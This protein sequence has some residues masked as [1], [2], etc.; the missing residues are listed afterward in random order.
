MNEVDISAYLVQVSYF[1]YHY[2]F[3]IQQN[4]S[5]Y[6]MELIQWVGMIFFGHNF[7]YFPEEMSPYE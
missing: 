3:D 4:C 2:D 5:I 7:E 6:G 1:L